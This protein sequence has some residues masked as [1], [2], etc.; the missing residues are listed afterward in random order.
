MATS[1]TH[2][3]YCPLALYDCWKQHK[4]EWLNNFILIYSYEKYHIRIKNWLKI[5][6]ECFGDLYFMFETHSCFH[7]CLLSMWFNW[8]LLAGGHHQHPCNANSLF[9]INEAIRVPI[10]LMSV[11]LILKFV[12]ITPQKIQIFSMNTWLKNS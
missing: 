6:I 8:K 4:I 1:I 7:C 12:E 11:I 9:N 3:Y 10:K 5:Y 2:L